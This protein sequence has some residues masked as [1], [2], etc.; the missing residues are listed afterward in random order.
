[1]GTMRLLSARLSS[2]EDVTIDLVSADCVDC[3][4]MMLSVCDGSCSC[5][6]Y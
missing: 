2:C 4:Y 6:L 1:M 5:G 3:G